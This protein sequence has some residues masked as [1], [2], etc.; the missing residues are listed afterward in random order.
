MCFLVVQ[1]V[2]MVEWWATLIRLYLLYVSNKMMTVT[3]QT[4]S[5]E[6]VHESCCNIML[7]HFADS[8]NV[9]L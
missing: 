1:N 8:P 6:S 7:F 9:G 5:Q 2:Y 4:Q 3:S